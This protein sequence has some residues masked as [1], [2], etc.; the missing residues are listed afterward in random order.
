M[1]KTVEN[2]KIKQEKTLEILSELSLFLE[3]G[4]KV[5]VKI[6]ETL[7]EKLLNSMKT[8][9]VEKLKVALIGGFS[10]GKTSIAAA[11]LEKLDQ[12]SMKISHEESSDEIK[13]YG[14][15][16]NIE[17]IDTPGL[18]GFKEKFDQDERQVKKY[19]EITEKYVSEA[20]LVLY[21]MNS[22]NPI[23]ESHKED[24]NWLFRDLNLLPRTIFV[25]SKFDEIVDVEDQK[26]YKE[27]FEIKRKNVT[28]RLGDLIN[29]EGKEVEK[30]SIV[31][32]AANPFD[33]GTEHWLS[34][35]KEFKKISHI[36]KLQEA[37]SK[38]IID[39]GG[40]IKI[41]NQTKKTIIQ[42]VLYKQL[43]MIQ[44]QDIKV[45]EEVEKLS[46]IGSIMNIDLQ[47]LEPKISNARINLKTFIMDYFTD[48]ILQ[49]SGTSLETIS[50]FMD[51]E[52]GEDGIN[53][54]T[55]IQNEFESQTSII[56]LELDKIKTNFNSEIDSF[57]KVI[58]SYSSDGIKYLADSKVINNTTILGA[59]NM[60]VGGFKTIG[61]DLSKYL[62]FK[63]W[64]ATK[65][66]NATN[67][68]FAVLGLAL[69]AWDSCEKAKKEREF[70][71]GIKEMKENFEKQKKEILKYIDGEE[72]I[73][74]T[75]PTYI[76]L[77]KSILLVEDDIKTI[78]GKQELLKQWVDMGK[79][80]EAEYVQI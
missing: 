51:R 43:P 60:I 68:A 61:V 52:I 7:K 79:I 56:S 5:G 58:T 16:D 33:L 55:K 25:L 76:S 35:M 64:G 49:L 26:A 6:D 38:K 18:F 44:E 80:I 78:E 46:E 36:S 8:V 66:A 22:I 41:V 13:I 21:V 23:K 14:V 45:G 32:V 73:N 2:F 69:E 47:A 29:L 4:E 37:T 40:I 57:S 63:P 31:A 54:N 39:N 72:F 15:G 28:N 3:F 59:R 12:S 77:Q 34:E 11:W 71:E 30:L 19:K 70:M 9:K 27:E 65:F 42:D 20:H 17:L 10:E 53:I 50:N 74:N 75:F 67:G 1:K 62:K 48:L 24:L